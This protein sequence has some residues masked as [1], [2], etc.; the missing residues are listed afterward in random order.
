MRKR[1]Q[2]A[3]RVMPTPAQVAE[4]VLAAYCSI[5]K[6][7]PEEVSAQFIAG[8]VAI[9]SKICECIAASLEVSWKVPLLG[10]KDLDPRQLTSLRSL[11]Q[12][13][14]RTF[15]GNAKEVNGRGAPH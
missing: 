14:S 11:I 7:R 15:H 4:G 8:D 13:F 6:R 1:Q 5:T 3:V 9:D 2:P 12:L 10:E